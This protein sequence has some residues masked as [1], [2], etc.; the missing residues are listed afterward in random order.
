MVCVNGLDQPC[1]M[2]TGQSRIVIGQGAPRTVHTSGRPIHMYQ[3]G[4][5]TE[6]ELRW[7]VTM[8]LFFY[9]DKKS[10]VLKDDRW[11]GWDEDRHCNPPTSSF[12]T[13]LEE[14]NI[15]RSV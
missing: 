9:L 8:W 2:H 6:T 15:G 3:A 1:S 10:S 14:I 13:R 4:T 5:G 12:P 7:D 11:E